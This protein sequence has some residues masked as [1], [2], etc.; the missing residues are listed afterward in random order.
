[1]NHKQKLVEI[2]H[3]SLDLEKFNKSHNYTNY[4]EEE[5]DDSQGIK[6]D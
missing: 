6:E 4:E 1:M 2:Y 3:E 5:E